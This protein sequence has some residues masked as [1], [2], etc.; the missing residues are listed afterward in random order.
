MTRQNPAE[1]RLDVA[2]QAAQ[3]DERLADEFVTESR[4]G[5]EAEEEDEEEEEE[6][7]EDEIEWN[8][9]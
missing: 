7:E 2:F 9:W 1:F 4:G 6:E 8:Y 5:N 3:T